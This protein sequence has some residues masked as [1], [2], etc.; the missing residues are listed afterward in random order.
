MKVDDCQG[1]IHDAWTILC[2][3]LSSLDQCAS[4]P[5]TSLAKECIFDAIESLQRA[6]EL[7][8]MYKAERKL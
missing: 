2:D 3:I 8:D 1:K 6:G 5:T 7:L 4:E